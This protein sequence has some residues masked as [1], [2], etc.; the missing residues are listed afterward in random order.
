MQRR[1]LFLIAIAA[2][3]M[4]V[5]AA[6]FWLMTATPAKAQCGSQASSCK[7]CHEVQAK[8][9]VNADGTGWHQSHA[10]GDFCYICHAGNNQATDKAEAHTG[11]V[12]PL[13][14]VEASC[15]QCHPADLTERSQVYATT[16]GVEFGSGGDA[17]V[18][19]TSPTVATEAPAVVESQV[20]ETNSLGITEIDVDDPNYVDYAQRYDQIV[21]GIQP[22]NWGNVILIA[23]ILMLLLGG[24]G[25]V[26]NREKLVSV[27]FGDTKK[28]GEEYPVEVVDML[29][30][31][32]KLKPQS[33]KSLKN[34]LDNPK[35]TEKVLGLIDEVISEE[36]KEE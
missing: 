34:I 33:R 4:L 22:T 6:S 21:L 1:R 8:M 35:K 32:S 17:S 16:L 2:G 5:L 18:A 14:D 12:A 28:A 11:M 13:A 25:Y 20:T 7:N 10:F 31:I 24:G 27:S 3:I 36:K 30:A 9:P 29:P 19:E 15:A 23:M 26:L